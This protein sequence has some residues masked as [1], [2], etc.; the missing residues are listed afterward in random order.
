MSKRETGKFSLMDRDDL[1]EFMTE[2]QKSE[3]AE[4]SSLPPQDLTD[5]FIRL[6]DYIKQK[7]K[8][9]VHRSVR[10]IAIARYRAQRDRFSTI[11]SYD[12]ESSPVADGTE[13]LEDS[14]KS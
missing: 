7:K 9:A 5:G 13:V 3:P 10:A 11:T 6:A 2:V 4:V 12:Q 14:I 8:P 1:H